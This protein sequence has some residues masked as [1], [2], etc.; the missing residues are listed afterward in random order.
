MGNFS[1]E[2]TESVSGAIGAAPLWNALMRALHQREVPP[3]PKIPR[4]LYFSETANAWLKNGELAENYEEVKAAAI[5]KIR[6]PLDSMKLVVDP[7]IPLSKQ[8]LYF[9]SSDPQEKHYWTLNGKIIAQNTKDFPFPL[10]RGSYKLSL[11]DE[12]KKVLD[13]VNFKVSDYSLEAR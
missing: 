13:E 7:D 8:R 11:L 6:Y 12:N 4:G 5:Y 2:P 10:R 3:D 9:Q 1:G